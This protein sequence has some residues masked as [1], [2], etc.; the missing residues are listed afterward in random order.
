VLADPDAVRCLEGIRDR[1]LRGSADTVSALSLPGSCP[2]DTLVLESKTNT[3]GIILRIL[4]PTGVGIVSYL[5]LS[6]AAAYEPEASRIAGLVCRK[7][8]ALDR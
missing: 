3:G 8:S 7:L 1:A 4:I 2:G 5:G 6:E